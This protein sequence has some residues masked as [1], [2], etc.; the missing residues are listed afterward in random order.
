M[1]EVTY[2]EIPHWVVGSV[3]GHPHQLK[4]AVFEGTTVAVLQGR[5]H[6]YEGFDVSEVQLT[7]RSLRNW[8]V[9]G[10]V[11]TSAS[12]A[13]AEEVTVGSVVAAHTVLDFAHRG[14]DG[15]PEVL[16]GTA[17]S[18]V[19]ALREA[20]DAGTGV[21]E[22]VHASVLGP[23]Y[24]TPAELE[25]LRAA[26]VATVSMSP[27]CELRAAQ[28]SG[29]EVAVVVVVTNVDGTSHSEVL[30]ASRRAREALVRPLESLARIWS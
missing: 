16:P 8:G 15:E 30:E 12:G 22:G 20:G 24:E 19:S 2:G 21:E 3:E 17:M 28:E 10:I 13:V 29:M 11:L 1:A 6:E 23:H 9:Q 27:A 18:L 4:L 14:A 26:G 7:V 25:V 5:V